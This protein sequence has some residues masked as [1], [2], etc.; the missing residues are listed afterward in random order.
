MRKNRLIAWFGAVS[1]GVLAL[2]ILTFAIESNHIVTD[3]ITPSLK[4][5]IV[6]LIIALVVCFLLSSLGAGMAIKQYKRK[7]VVKSRFR[8]LFLLNPS[9]AAVFLGLQV[10]YLVA[11]FQAKMGI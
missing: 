6:C 4:L 3:R 9:Y 7:F 8:Y 1:W 2:T 5:L 10:F 11:A